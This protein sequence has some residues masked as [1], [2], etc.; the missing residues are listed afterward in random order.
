[1]KEVRNSRVK[2]VKCQLAAF[3]DNKNHSKS[4]LHFKHFSE[5]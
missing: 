5:Y 4:R 1:M 2:V 3:L